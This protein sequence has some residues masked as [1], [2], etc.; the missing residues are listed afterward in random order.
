MSISDYY[1]DT[2]TPQTVAL[3]SD[4]MGGNTEVWTSGT[5]FS[6]RIETIENKDQI[7][8]EAG[9][10]VSSDILFCSTSESLTTDMRVIFGGNTYEITS[11][12]S[13]TDGTGT[14]HHQEIG[15]LYVE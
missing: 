11:L 14:A 8:N 5:A 12:L 3:T 2:I 7:F 6:G 4:G 13:P 15:L 9:K 1:T 10:L